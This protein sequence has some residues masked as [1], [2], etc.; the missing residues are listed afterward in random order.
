M[1][2]KENGQ[3]T[4]EMALSLTLFCLLIFGMIDFGRIFSAYLTLNHASREAAR[5]AS[6]GGTDAVIRSK[7]MDASKVLNNSGKNVQISPSSSLRVRGEYVTVKMSYPVSI[8]TPL[9]RTILP[10]PFVV[11]NETTMRVE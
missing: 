9:L 10:D 4:V 7:A 11:S 2:K 8:S 3:A 6:V 5:V 1:I